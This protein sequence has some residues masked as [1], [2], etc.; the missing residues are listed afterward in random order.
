MS[1]INTIIISDDTQ[2][3]LLLK[4][5]LPE[6]DYKIIFE[7]TLLQQLL[8]TPDLTKPELIIVVLE[9]TDLAIL[10]QLK[11]IYEQFPMPIVIFTNDDRDEAIEHAINVG[12]SAYI[13]DGLSKNRIVPIVR[14]ACLRFEQHQKIQKELYE[15]KTS[16]ADRKII[17]RA[18][19]LVMQQRQCTEDEAYKLLRTAAMKQNLRLSVLAQNIINTADLLGR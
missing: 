13:V 12:V 18:K 4:Q 15:L 11:M 9:S 3:S 14:T 1:S 2:S 5:V 16:L 8:A 19:G 6:S 7:G 10:G 17:D